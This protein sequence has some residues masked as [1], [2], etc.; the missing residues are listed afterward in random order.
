M[1]LLLFLSS[2]RY[3]SLQ[4]LGPCLALMSRNGS[5]LCRT[6]YGT[7]F[8]RSHPKDNP[9]HIGKIV[10]NTQIVAYLL[11][12]FFIILILMLLQKLLCCLILY[13]SK[14]NPSF[15]TWQ[16]KRLWSIGPSEFNHF[17]L[18]FDR[19]KEWKISNEEFCHNLQ[20]CTRT[21]NRNI[22]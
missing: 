20:K 2:C 13:T 10:Q 16:K 14:I 15:S 11:W 1:N 3:Q 6:R 19:K 5:L 18:T 7:R 9:S 17:T 22:S 12:I 21:L 8:N 4:S